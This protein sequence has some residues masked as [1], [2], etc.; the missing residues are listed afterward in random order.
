MAANRSVP[1]QDKP[2]RHWITVVAVGIAVVLILVSIL[3]GWLSSRWAGEAETLLAAGSIDD[4]EVKARAALEIRDE[5]TRAMR[6]LIEI[7]ALSNKAEAIQLSN[8]LMDTE[9]ADFDDQIRFAE[10]LQEVGDAEGARPVVELLRE[11]R[12]TDAE[13]ILLE[14][15]QAALDGNGELALARVE[16]ALS[17]DEG[18]LKGKLLRGLLL[19]KSDDPVRRLQGK[20]ALVD[21]LQSEDRVGI[22]AL[23]AL[24]ASADLN[25]Y[26][27]ERR[28][29][30]DQLLNHPLAGV[31]EQLLAL[32]NMIVSDLDGRGGYIDRA[33]SLAEPGDSTLLVRWLIAV[34]EPERALEL[35]PEDVE[36]D[37]NYFDARISALMRLGRYEEVNEIVQGDSAFLSDLEKASI[38]L[39]L[40][41][42]SE[43]PEVTNERWN[44]V[45]RLAVEDDRP[46]VLVGLAQNAQARG[47]SKRTVEC[48]RVA[49]EIGI[50][51]RE[52][53]AL[54]QQYF[55]ATLS[56]PDLE[57]SL[58]VAREIAERYPDELLPQN[59][60]AYLS[61]LLDQN[62]DEALIASQALVEA[63]PDVP[64]FRTTL[65]LALLK[66]GSADE[67][68]TVLDAD[69]IDWS[70]QDAGS[71]VI[72][73]LVARKVGRQQLALELVS[74]VDPKA[75]LPAERELLSQVR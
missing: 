22:Q 2:K 67:A 8:R 44:T 29:L 23:M 58:R 16:D 66:A 38:Q 51:D 68:W 47:D 21:A 10:L 7:M 30:A 69:M 25:I 46:D 6:V 41:S 39:Y 50:G 72:V 36:G 11:Q 5:N 48:Y 56:Q 63:N 20:D 19:T 61:L 37:R 74:D 57:E 71:R 43:N 62:V 28:S 27:E 73:A 75:I 3:P 4:A 53:R 9:R 13:V 33:V 24:L 32:Q 35:I 31:S 70:E 55:L 49:F 26:P 17:L 18:M 12:P 59:N 14:A 52:S 15:R 42:P 45:F 40:T 54:W 34:G 60:L 65:A 1:V 64:G